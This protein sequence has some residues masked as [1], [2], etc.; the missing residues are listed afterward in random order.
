[1]FCIRKNTANASYCQEI[2]FQKYSVFVKIVPTQ[3]WQ[4]QLALALA[5]AKVVSVNTCLLM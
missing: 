4:L 3:P 1:M 2:Y 5:L